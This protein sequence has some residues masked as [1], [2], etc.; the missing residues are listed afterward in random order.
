MRS[1][2]DLGLT[3]PKPML[4]IYFMEGTLPIEVLKN[5]TPFWNSTAAPII[6]AK[7]LIHVSSIKEN[8]G[9]KKQHTGR[10]KKSTSSNL[11]QETSE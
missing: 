9:W 2:I 4:R 10:D 1:E 6:R 3:A 5:W 11:R 8:Q 7:D